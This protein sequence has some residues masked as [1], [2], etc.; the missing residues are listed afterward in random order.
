MEVSSFVSSKA[1]SSRKELSIVHGHPKAQSFPRLKRVASS[2]Q[3]MT[4]VVQ[5]HTFL[6][7]R[8]LETIA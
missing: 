7:G 1:S 6:D 4:N 2:Q 3:A 8:N 5:V